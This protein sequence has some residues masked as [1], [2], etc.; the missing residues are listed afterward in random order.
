VGA[1]SVQLVL[2]GLRMMASR[3]PNKAANIILVPF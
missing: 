1:D 2:S 3:I